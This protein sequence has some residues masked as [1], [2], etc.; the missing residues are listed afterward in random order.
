S[1]GC[2]KGM[3]GSMHLYAKEHGFWGSVP[4]V[5][6]TISMAVGAGLAAQMDKPDRKDMDVGV[7]YFG[8]GAAEEGVLHES[9]NFAAKFKVP[10]IFVCENNLFSSHLHILLRQPKDKV[11]RYAESHDVNV[12][13]VDGNDIE[14]V[15]KAAKR[16]VDAARNGEGPGFL[17][18]VTYRW[19][20]HV[21][22]S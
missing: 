17:E 13:V 14:A 18:A 8:D 10:V 16:L 21:G 19:R 11:A 4:I 7:A 22:P 2:S 6:A 5:G 12:E 20:G 3:G 9:L 15:S 1:T